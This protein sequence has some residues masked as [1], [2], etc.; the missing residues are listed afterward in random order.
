MSRLAAPSSS[1]QPRL[2]MRRQGARPTVGSKPAQRPSGERSTSI[3]VRQGLRS[4][5]EPLGPSEQR[6]MGARFGHDFSTVRVHDGADADRAAQAISANAFAVGEDIVFAEGRYAPETAQGQ[7]LLAHELTHVVQHDRT[8]SGTDPLALAD[9][10]MTLSRPADAAEQE[11]TTTAGDIAGG[12]SVQVQTAPAAVVSRD[13]MDWVSDA[14][15]TVGGAATSAYNSYEKATDFKSGL[16][17]LDQGVDWVEK[18]AAKGNQDMVNQTKDIPVLGSLAKGS[19]WLSDEMTQATGG[20]VKGIG[21][22]AGGIG[23]AVAHPIDTAAGM[24][25]LLEHNATVP[26]LGSTLKAAHG[27]YDLA[28]NNG[29]QYGNS[30]GDLANH[31]LNPLQSS[32]DDANY[33][34]ALAKGILAPGDAGWQTWQDKP[35][36]ALTRAVTNIAPML[37]GGEETAGGKT[38]IPEPVPESVPPTLR[39][40]YA[41]PGVPIPR[42]FNPDIPIIEPGKTPGIPSSAPPPSSGPIVIGPDTRPSPGVTP[43]DTVRPPDT[44][45][46]MPAIPRGTP[47]IEELAKVVGLN[48]GMSVVELLMKMG[49][50][51]TWV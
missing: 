44:I 46:G 29:G 9:A 17:V 27:A 21:D 8:A 38:P 25:G 37:L 45:P 15:S 16:G 26:F 33:D 51:I 23:G 4:S 6:A 14:A 49:R 22:V 42:P 28:A 36:E 5:H 18:N 43:P 39:T 35:A 32:Q 3:S 19:A 7:R 20:V 48:P 24:E 2:V 11:A 1:R 50:P 40:P 34:A 30:W 13:L 10:A 41:P 47:G 31:V 12:Q